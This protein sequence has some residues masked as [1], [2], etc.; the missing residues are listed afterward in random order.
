MFLSRNRNSDDTVGQKFMWSKSHRR[1]CRVPTNALSSLSIYVRCKNHY[2]CCELTKKENSNVCIKYT[3]TLRAGV[4]SS[5][6][7]SSRV[8][9]YVRKMG[10]TTMFVQFKCA[11]SQLSVNF[12]PFK[13]PP[14]RR[15]ISTTQTLR[16]CKPCSK[17]SRSLITLI[18]S[19]SITNIL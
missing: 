1:E 13:W 10:P 12:V 4:S 5:F 3:H 8:S 9:L 17:L 14:I 11:R 15:Y 19:V 7:S 6:S 2:L 18:V 16:L